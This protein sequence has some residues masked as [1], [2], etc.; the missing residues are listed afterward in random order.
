[1]CNH[2]T[3]ILP[4]HR[5]TV[6]CA[7][8]SWDY[9]A[10]VCRWANAQGKPFGRSDVLVAQALTDVLGRLAS[11][12]S[13]KQSQA[14]LEQRFQ[15]GDQRRNALMECCRMLANRMEMEELFAA[16]MVRNC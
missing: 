1:M 4:S 10:V 5:R 13:L 3:I 8:L 12:R 7:T 14:L 16:V 15:E 11:H 2:G 9:V 6:A